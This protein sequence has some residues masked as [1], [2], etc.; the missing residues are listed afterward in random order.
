MDLLKE[1][2]HYVSDTEPP[3]IF[4]RWSFLCAVGALLERNVSYGDGYFTCFP[5]MFV[6]LM[7]ESGTRKSTAINL[8]K[9]MLRQTGYSHFS[10]EQT[11]KEKY[12]QDLDEQHNAFENDLGNITTAAIFGGNAERESQVTPSFIV[13]GEFNDFIGNG[14]IEFMSILGNLWDWKGV[15]DK[16]I[17]TGKSVSIPNPTISILAGNTATGFSLAFP[18]TAIGQGF[19]SRLILIHS[20][21]S[22]R[23]R[24]KPVFPAQDIAKQLVAIKTQVQGNMT[25]TRVAELLLD[26]IYNNPAKMEDARFGAYM[27][28]R[29][30]QLL[31]LTM[32]CTALRGCMQITEGDV[33]FANTI[34]THAEYLMPKALGEFGKAKSSDVANTILGMI[35][36]AGELVTLEHIWST[37]S[38]DLDTNTQLM[39][40]LRKLIGAGKI[41]TASKDD[42]KG[43]KLSGFLPIRRALTEKSEFI[44][45]NLLTAEER[46]MKL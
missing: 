29:Y 27:S 35:H 44:D 32:I 5:N 3:T 11:S 15:Y 45:F 22:G 39:D 10:A 24:R 42:G 34:L 33:I 23:L 31:K 9:D 2:L 40:I 6:M 41:Q 25:A 20:T 1:Y 13:A 43:G 38:Q 30:A 12:L 26:E 14:N 18:P 16:R 46:N 4:Q 8:A 37:V 21:P 36:N 28:R 19:F 17:K 7:G